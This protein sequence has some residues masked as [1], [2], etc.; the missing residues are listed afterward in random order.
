MSVR[1][2]KRCEA[3]KVGGGQ[4]ARRTCIYPRYCWQHAIQQYGLK[5]AKSG[6][7]NTGIGLYATRNIP[8]NTI[9][10]PYTGAI[11]TVPINGSYVLEINKRRF[12]DG[13]STQSSMAR[14]ANDCR[15]RNR[16]SREC[17]G[18]NAKFTSTRDRQGA[19]LKSIGRIPAGREIHVAY[20][21]GY[22]R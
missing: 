22:W 15:T 7:P 13:K 10:A 3:L 12:I 2:C 1:E 21:A 8:P 11:S 16:R 5:L 18:N 4:C 19:N 17:T 14:Y 20:S 6:I 9:I